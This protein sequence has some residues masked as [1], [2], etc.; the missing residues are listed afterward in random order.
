MVC[1]SRPY[2]SHKIRSAI[3]DAKSR[4]YF[5]IWD[6]QFLEFFTSS[7]FPSTIS[8][9]INIFENKTLVFMRLKTNCTFN[10]RN[11]KGIQLI[12]R[13][14]LGLSHF[15]EHKF[16][17]SFWDC[18]NPICTCWYEIETTAHYLLHCSILA[19]SM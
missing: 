7:F 16:K 11:P 2:N 1:L 6:K 4:N 8:E 12:N 19:M 18:L 17:H 13:L 14:V 10:C 15:H 3:Y 9:S 5:S